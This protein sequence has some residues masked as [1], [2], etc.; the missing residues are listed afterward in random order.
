MYV[1]IDPTPTGEPVTSATHVLEFCEHDESVAV[2]PTYVRNT[3]IRLEQSSGVMENGKEIFFEIKKAL[4]YCDS[5]VFNMH[6]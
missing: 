3:L 1:Y 4:L 2:L 6:L 5:I